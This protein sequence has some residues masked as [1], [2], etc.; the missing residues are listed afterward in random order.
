M[1]VKIKTFT[2]EQKLREFTTRR[3]MLEGMVMNFFK[4]NIISDR[5]VEIYKE[6]KICRNGKNK[7]KIPLFLI[8]LTYKIIIVFRGVKACKS[9]MYD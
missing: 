8:I 3:P 1:K 5:N 9:K 6:I 4:S 2:D 7:Y